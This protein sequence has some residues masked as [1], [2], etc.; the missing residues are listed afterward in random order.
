MVY[1]LLLCFLVFLIRCSAIKNYLQKNNAL[2]FERQGDLGSVNE[3]HD[4]TE[5]VR[6]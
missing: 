4:G 3:G 6:Q 2:P 1:S 5:R